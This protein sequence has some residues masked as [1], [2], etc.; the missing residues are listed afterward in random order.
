VAQAGEISSGPCG[1][2]GLLGRAA[3]K[4]PASS[5]AVRTESPAP[6]TLRRIEGGQF[7]LPLAQIHQQMA[8]RTGVSGRANRAFACKSHGASSGDKL[9]NRWSPQ[10]AKAGGSSSVALAGR[11]ERAAPQ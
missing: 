6:R 1:R 11:Q 8:D 4:P 3:M 10:R 9:D 7:G 5:K 2:C